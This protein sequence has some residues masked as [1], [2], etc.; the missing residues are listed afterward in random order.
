VV[1]PSALKVEHSAHPGSS[2]IDANLKGSTFIDVGLQESSFEN[3]AF[4]GAVFKNVCFRGVHIEDANL[5]EAR[6]NGV[7]IT[8]LLRAYQA[9]KQP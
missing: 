1:T 8:E 5:E 2:F 3:A 4:T 9:R 7:L 6:I